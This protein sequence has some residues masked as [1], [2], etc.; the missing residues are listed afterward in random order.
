MNMETKTALDQ[1]VAQL[2]KQGEELINQAEYQ[3]ALERGGIRYQM[4]EWLTLRDYAKRFGLPNTMVVTNWIARG[5]IPPENVLELPEL[6]DIRLVRAI[7][8]KE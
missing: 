7:P 4:G 1:D 8:Y 2:L 6:N 5:I 3:L